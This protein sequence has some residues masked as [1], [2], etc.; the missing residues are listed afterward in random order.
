MKI[1]Q[2]FKPPRYDRGVDLPT[3][4]VAMLTKRI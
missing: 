1:Q 2:T 4:V 3:G